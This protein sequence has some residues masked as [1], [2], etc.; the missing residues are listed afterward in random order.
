MAEIDKIMFE[1][2]RAGDE[3]NR[4]R[5]VYFTELEEGDRDVAI[6]Q[7]LAGEHVFDG[8]I[9]AHDAVGAKAAIASLIV[10]LNGGE[11]WNSP[12]LRGALAD[13]LVS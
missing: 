9:S 5:V 13:F 12:R 6:S 7:A 1:I 3:P 4:Y 11:D 10:R 8:F 2:Y